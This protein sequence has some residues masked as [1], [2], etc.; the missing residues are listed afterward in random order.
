LGVTKGSFYWY[1]ENRAALLIAVLG[2]WEEEC[3]EAVIA[4]IERI[5]DPRERLLSL[6]DDA[7]ANEPH[8]GGHASPSGILFSRAFEQAIADAADDPTVG[9][10]LRRVSERRVA[11]LEEYYRALGFPLDEARH[12]ALLVYAAYVRADR[13]RN[14]CPQKCDSAALHCL[15]DLLAQMSVFSAQ[16]PDNYDRPAIDCWVT[17][18]LR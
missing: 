11:Y 2:R 17:S 15:I 16:M 1:F 13:Y 3:T 9:P 7:M 10:V 4:A 18:D 6:F 14:R 5:S 12:R 8:G